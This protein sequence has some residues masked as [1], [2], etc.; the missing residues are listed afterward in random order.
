MPASWPMV[1]K[2]ENGNQYPVDDDR[3][4][5]EVNTADQYRERLAFIL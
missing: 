2:T 5:L 4:L 1:V 3:Q